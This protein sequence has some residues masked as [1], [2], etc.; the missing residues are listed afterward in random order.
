M[1]QDVELLGLSDLFT[2]KKVVSEGERR[3]LV[4]GKW[5]LK[6]EFENSDALATL[7]SEHPLNI[8]VRE[9]SSMSLLE[10]MEVIW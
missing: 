10:L 4:M 1:H 2:V 3:H 6:I 7:W 8:Q 9:L 5:S